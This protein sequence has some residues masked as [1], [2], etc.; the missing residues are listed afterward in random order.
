MAIAGGKVLI[1]SPFSKIAQ[2]D[3]QAPGQAVT[4]SLAQNKDINSKQI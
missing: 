4:A 2:Q 1:H 3:D